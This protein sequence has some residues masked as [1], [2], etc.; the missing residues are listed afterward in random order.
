[1]K[2]NRFEKYENE[3]KEVCDKIKVLTVLCFISFFV[4]LTGIL[5]TIYGVLSGF[6]FP[7]FSGL[8]C[9]I[10]GAVAFGV[11]IRSYFFYKV[12]LSI[13]EGIIKAAKRMDYREPGE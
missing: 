5:I 1:M 8:L 11:N 10:S 7:L 6:M 4:V 2:D 13:A 9:S 3:K 12:S